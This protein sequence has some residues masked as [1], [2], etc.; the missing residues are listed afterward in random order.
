MTHGC[1]GERPLGTF[2]LI[3]REDL[4]ALDT[5]FPHVIP[6]HLLAAVSAV[7]AAFPAPRE[8]VNLSKRDV[9]VLRHIA[10][11][12]PLSQVARRLYVTE[13]TV[14][15]QVRSI[16]RKLEVGS[17]GDALDRARGLGLLNGPESGGI[18]DQPAAQNVTT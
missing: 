12:V 14:K 3:P 1:S 10:T 6:A 5:V 18:P 15:T 4:L 11:G 2:A 7:P 9:E 8:P 17:R 13:N 16:Y